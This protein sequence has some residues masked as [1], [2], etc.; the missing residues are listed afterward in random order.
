LLIDDVNRADDRILRGIMQLLQNYELVSWKLPK[1]WQIVL[2]ANP[3]S[4]DYSVTPMDDAMLTRM[5]HISMVFDVNDWVNWANENDVHQDGI[6][7]VLTHQ[8]SLIGDRTTPR[9]LVQFFQNIETI[10]DWKANLPLIQLIGDATLDE[11]TVNSFINFI[12]NDR[13]LLISPTEIINT[14]NFEKEIETQLK[15]LTLGDALRV[16]ILATICTRLLQTVSKMDFEPTEKQLENI[17]AFI[18]LDLLPNDL[19]LTFAQ[20][21]VQSKNQH[22]K[23]IIADPVIGKLVLGIVNL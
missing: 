16:D 7:F 15:E 10:E 11:T 5:L 22:L 13:Q 4:G 21:L 3:D 2:T 23:Q 6:N 9:T 19:R 12:Q 14:D 17:K 20:D 18:K 8:Q 1:N